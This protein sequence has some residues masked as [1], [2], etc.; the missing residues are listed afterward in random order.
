MNKAHTK[1]LEQQ[2]GQIEKIALGIAA[3]DRGELFDH[4]QVMQEIENRIKQAQKSPESRK[5]K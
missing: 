1:D 5:L 3:A 2:P 4:D